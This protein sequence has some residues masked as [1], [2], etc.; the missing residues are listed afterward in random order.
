MSVLFLF[1]FVFSPV[2]GDFDYLQLVL[3][4]PR[5]FCKSRYCPNPIP[6]NFTIHGLWPDK[7]RIMPINCPAKESYKSITDFK[8]IKLLEQH[9]PDLTSNQGSAEFWRYQYKKHGTCSVDL[10]NQEQYFDLA[11]ELKEKFDL[12]KTLK[13]HGITP[14]KTN[15]VIDVEKAIKA[16]TKEVPNLNC[17]GDSSQ[18][19]ELLEI[20]ICFNR[21]GTT[22]IACRRR[23]NN[24]PN[25]NQKI[26]LPP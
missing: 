10:Y 13:N 7:Q 12:L 3:Q 14:S 11:I 4:W 20:G 21:E 26:T 15:T 22:V 24:H 19:M 25:G 16:V 6:R 17:I 5:S 2:C 1:L 8:K 23:W 9:W 18:T